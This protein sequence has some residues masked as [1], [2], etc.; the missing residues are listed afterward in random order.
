MEEIPQKHS[1]AADLLLPCVTM[2][3][4]GRPYNNCDDDKD[5]LLIN[6]KAWST[7]LSKGLH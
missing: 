3:M 5:F 2:T 7:A 4:K 1:A 6:C